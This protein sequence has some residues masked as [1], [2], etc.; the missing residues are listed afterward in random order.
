MSDN[1][2]TTID[3]A[4]T[5]Q[6]TTANYL[7]NPCQDNYWELIRAAQDYRDYYFQEGSKPEPHSIVTKESSD[8]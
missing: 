1:F 4:A 8:E 2:Y 7:A 5:L 6:L 3:K